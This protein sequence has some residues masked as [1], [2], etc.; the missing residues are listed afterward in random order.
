MKNLD[1]KLEQ[2]IRDH[3]S[4]YVEQYEGLSEKQ[5]D[6]L[7]LLE[8]KITNRDGE[9]VAIIDRDLLG[10]Y[11]SLRLSKSNYHLQWAVGFF[12]GITSFFTAIEVLYVM[13][14]IH[15]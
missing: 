3:L 15:P 1:G 4:K 13:N 9:R 6:G 11:L 14:V 8:Y 5:K 12:A 2:A 10:D 7:D